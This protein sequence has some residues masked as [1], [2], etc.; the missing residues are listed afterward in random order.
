V[1]HR[2]S[3]HFNWSLKPAEV[4]TRNTD[5]E[6]TPVGIWWHTVT[7]GRGSEGETGEWS[8]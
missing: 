1:R 4:Y 8:G 2:V 6:Y 7:H 5:H 3:S